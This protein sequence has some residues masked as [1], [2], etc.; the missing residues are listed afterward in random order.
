[1]GEASVTA[2]GRKRIDFEATIAPG[3]VGRPRPFDPRVRHVGEPTGQLHEARRVLGLTVR[4]YRQ[5]ARFGDQLALAPISER[6][7]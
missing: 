4:C 2:S 7:L 6:R 5:F 1:L 3:A